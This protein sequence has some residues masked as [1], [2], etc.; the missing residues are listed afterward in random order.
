MHTPLPQGTKSPVLEG[1]HHW[2]AMLELL[3]MSPYSQPHPCCRG[4][5]SA[6]AYQQP[7]LVFAQPLRPQAPPPP[8]GQ[9]SGLAQHKAGQQSVPAGMEAGDGKEESLQPMALS[10]FQLSEEYG[11]L[12]PN[13]LVGHGRALGSAC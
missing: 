8:P 7:L 6:L 10:R 13:P 9:G 1:G 3:P 2:G 12:L 5:S 11:F 4:R